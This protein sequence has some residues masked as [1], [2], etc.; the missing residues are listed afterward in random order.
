MTLINAT[1]ISYY[2]YCQRRMWLHSNGIRMEH[3]SEVVAEGRLIGETTYQHRPAK[4]TEI[5]ISFQYAKDILLTCKLDYYDA[6][7]KIVHEVKKSDSKEIAHEWQVKF[8]LWVLLLN[9][10][11]RATGI[12]EYPKFRETKE[13]F[14]S[15]ADIEELKTIVV[16]ANDILSGE[17]I[18]PKIQIKYCKNC[19]YYELCYISE[20]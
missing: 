12:L 1:L 18:P 20:E 5:E 19:S 14:L 15:D 2:F 17:A 9:G 7:N 4:Y 8:Y 6:K 13:I 11:E 16:N 10:I 3:A